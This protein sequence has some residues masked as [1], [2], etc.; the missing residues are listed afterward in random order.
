MGTSWAPPLDYRRRPILGLLRPSELQPVGLPS[1]E[2]FAGSRAEA[3]GWGNL[4][5]QLMLGEML[6]TGDCLK[7]PFGSSRGSGARSAEAGLVL[8]LGDPK[9]PKRWTS[10]WFPCTNPPKMVPLQ[11]TTDPCV[12]FSPT[13]GFLFLPFAEYM[14]CSLLPCCLSTGHLSL[15][16]I[17][18]LMF[19]TYA[20]GV[21]SGCVFC[22]GVPV[23]KRVEGE[24]PFGESPFRG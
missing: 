10:C 16:D 6:L 21:S 12:C 23:L 18:S 4:P 17:L 20:Q 13:L 15:L 14:F 1:E 8:K 5:A 19:S 11:K 2:V 9:P 3:A 7:R 24:I 22:C